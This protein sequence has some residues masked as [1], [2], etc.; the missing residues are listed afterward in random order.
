[1]NVYDVFPRRNLPVEAE[2]WGRETEQRIMQLENAV[3]GANDAI[4]GQ[5]RTQA[6]TL[7]AIAGQLET[8]AAVYDSLED[9]VNG[10]DIQVQR[11]NELYNHLPKAV[12]A[13][14]N[15]KNFGLTSTGWNTIHTVTLTAPQAGQM[16]LNVVASGQLEKTTNANMQLNVRISRDGANYSPTVAGV[17][18]P[19]FGVFVNT[20][21]VSHSWTL[22]VTNG[23]KVTVAIQADPTATWPTRANSYVGLTAFGVVM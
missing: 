15:R 7:Q 16:V 3:L 2:E 17:A 14:G 4:A 12:Q 21:M 22:A 11:V 5:N 23:Q 20:F 18:S 8:V 10:L 13:S 1:M 9:N 6:S 19:P